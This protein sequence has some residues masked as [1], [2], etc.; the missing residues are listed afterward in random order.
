M[1]MATLSTHNRI[2]GPGNPGAKS[3]ALTRFAPLL[4]KTPFLALPFNAITPGVFDDFIARAGPDRTDEAGAKR[5]IAKTE[6]TN[7]ELAAMRQAVEPFNGSHVA[8]RSD[9]CTAGGVGLWHTGFML[10]KEKGTDIR[11]AAIANQILQSEYSADVTAFKQRCGLPMEQHPGVMAMPVNGSLGSAE[12]DSRGII[13]T[14]LHANVITRFKGEEALINMGMGIG[15]ANNRF[16]YTNLA[17]GFRRIDFTELIELL[18]WNKP[19]MKGLQRGE[20]VW[21]NDILTQE[22]D[23]IQAAH[24]EFLRFILDDPTGR[25]LEA[26]RT[27]TDLIAPQSLYLELAHANLEDWAV[28]QCSEAALEDVT[29]PDMPSEEKVLIIEPEWARSNWVNPFGCYVSGRKDVMSGEVVYLDKETLAKLPELNANHRNYI[30][31]FDASTIEG[32]SLATSFKDYSNAAAIIFNTCDVKFNLLTHLNGALREAGI[33]L[34]AGRVDKKF[35]QGLAKGEVAERTVTV[36]ANDA[37][38]EAFV[39]AA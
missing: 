19:Y 34:L 38:E 23:P 24:L 22:G 6:F 18:T 11:V 39:A 28:V 12:L 27:L 2:I 32:F 15:G 1:G 13:T 10:A 5:A 30:L 3:S 20:V 21:M 8:V 17:S 31:I 25:L 35:L 9:E 33:V 16:P 4:E 7:D 37:E 14:L 26:L 29:K 36:Y